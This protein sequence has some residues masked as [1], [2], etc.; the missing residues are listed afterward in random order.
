MSDFQAFSIGIEAMVA[1]LCLAAFISKKKKYM[2]GF[3][4]AFAV[5]VLYDIARLTNAN[6]PELYLDLSFFLATICALASAWGIY[7]DN[8]PMQ[9]V[10]KKAKKKR[11]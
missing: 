2:A 3:T 4:V 7:E 5:Y 1:L 6:V 10:A 11:K 8:A 9:A